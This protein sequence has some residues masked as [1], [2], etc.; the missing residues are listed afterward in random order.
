M[1]KK[2]NLKELIEMVKKHPNNMDLGAHVRTYI[3]T[4]MYEKKNKTK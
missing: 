1:E 2:I 4:K 3:Y